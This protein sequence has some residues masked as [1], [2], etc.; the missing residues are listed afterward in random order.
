[1]SLS[2]GAAWLALAVACISCQKAPDVSPT[3]P[4]T[5]APVTTASAA[6]AAPPAPLAAA[7]LAAAPPREGGKAVPP[8]GDVPSPGGGD[9]P[10]SPVYPGESA[11]QDGASELC[12]VLFDLPTTRR[13]ACCNTTPGAG[14]RAE[15]LRNVSGALAD[16]AITV[17]EAAVGRCKDAMTAAT[18]GCDWVSAFPLLP[19]APAE[20]SRLTI[21]HRTVGQSCRSS[22][23]CAGDAHCDGVGPI[24]PGICKPP[25]SSGACGHVVDVLATYLRI[26]SSNEAHP[27]CAGY[28]DFRQCADRV[29][30]G[31]ACKRDEACPSGSA[32]VGGLCAM[33]TPGEVGQPC[34]GGRCAKGLLC[35]L[36]GCVAPLAEG[37]A[38]SRSDECRGECVRSAPTDPS[39]TCRARCLTGVAPATRLR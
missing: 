7:P 30:V 10:V 14:M 24:T 4:L 16:G 21:G 39:G 35:R 23:E 1:M 9:A 20:C 19:P 5:A 28:C 25:S 33:G 31:G 29:P 36:S 12:S 15:C 18:A 2:S 22:Y 32:C 34:F 27:E 3:A 11:L 37:A 8:V 6:S 17:D 38:C 26:S 13:A